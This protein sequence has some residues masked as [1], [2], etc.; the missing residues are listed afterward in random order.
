MGIK[1]VIRKC[2]PRNLALCL[3]ALK[4]NKS[5]PGTKKL[6]QRE[7]PESSS[8]VLRTKVAIMKILSG[9]FFQS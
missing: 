7:I 2:K 8:L 6:Q 3:L 4:E 9:S 1:M 5:Q